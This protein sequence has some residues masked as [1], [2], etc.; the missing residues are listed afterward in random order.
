MNEYIF[1]T[2]E[3]NTE[4]P[5][6][7]YEIDNCQ[8]LGR[9]QGNTVQEAQTNL[10]HDNLWIIEAGF[11]THKFIAKQLLNKEQRKDIRTVVDFV[12]KNKKHIFKEYEDINS[13]VSISLAR[14]K[15]LC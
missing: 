13:Q 14:L 3:G 2:T 11:D 1:Y 7:D 4:A 6:A 12:C 5:N 9:S 10:L 15:E 8:M